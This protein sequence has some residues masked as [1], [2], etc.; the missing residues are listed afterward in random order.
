MHVP[1]RVGTMVRR[2]LPLAALNATGCGAWDLLLGHLIAATIRC[3]Y[4]VYREIVFEIYPRNIKQPE[5]LQRARSQFNATLAAAADLRRQALLMSLHRRCA[6]RQ[7]SWW[8][9]RK[10]IPKYV[11]PLFCLLCATGLQCCFGGIKQI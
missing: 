2:C 10:G 7:K 3:D 9:A 4:S 11:S 6:A 5:W 8:D 1:A